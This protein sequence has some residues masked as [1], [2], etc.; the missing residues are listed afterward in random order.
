[1][2][3][4]SN[5]GQ[6]ILGAGLLSAVIAYWLRVREQNQR[7]RRELRGLLRLIAGEIARNVSTLKWYEKKPRVIIAISPERVLK[8]RN[9]DENRVRLAQLMRS[10]E[11]FD[12]IFSYYDAVVQAE[13][14]A[15]WKLMSEDDEESKEREKGLYDHVAL[16]RRAAKSAYRAIEQEL[17]HAGFDSSEIRKREKLL[18]EPDASENTDE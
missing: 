2:E 4:L 14:A 1:V 9:W 17:E 7:D 6:I 12:K 15:L 10:G 5:V 3:L 18:P 13:D 16:N 8:S 11:R